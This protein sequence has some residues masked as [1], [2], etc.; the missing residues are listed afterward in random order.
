MLAYTIGRE[1]VVYDVED[2]EHFYDD[3]P[4]A[5]KVANGSE[6]WYNLEKRD[7][8]R[9]GGWRRRKRRRRRRRESMSKN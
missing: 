8:S 4:I 6:P 3:C 2:T 9:E 1:N 7:E 5:E